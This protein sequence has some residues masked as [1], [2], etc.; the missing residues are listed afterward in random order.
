MTMLLLLVGSFFVFALLRIPLA[1]SLGLSS[2]LVILFLDVSLAT[3]MNNLYEGINQFTLLAVPLFLIAG[4]LMNEGKVTERLIQF[5]DSVVGHIRG[6]LGH[7]NVFVSMIF[8]G[9]S[10]SSA[11]DT[12]GIGSVLI[13]AMVK[14][15]YDKPFTVAITACSS[16]MG[17]IIPPS[18]PMIIYGSFG[19]VSIGSLFLGG[20]IPGILI[21]LTQMGVTY[22]Y[23]RKRNYP[24]GDPPSF[25]R[26]I[27]ATK[28][29][30]LPLGMPLLIVGG[31]LIGVF[32]ATE[33]SVMAVV[34]GLSLIFLIYKS[35]KLSQL[36]RILSESAVF[37]ALPMFAV[38]NAS[39]FGW[40]VAYLE[41]PERMVAL[42]QALTTSYYGIFFAII[43]ML[44]ILGTFLS[45]I[46]IIIIFLPILQAL[47]DLAG[48]H[49]VHLGVITV[50][51]LAIGLITPPY[52]ICLLIAV[53]IAELSVLKAFQAC[54]LLIAVFI[55]II[56]LCVIFPDLV[57][58]IPRTFMPRF[59]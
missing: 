43:A 26:I 32:T 21:G 46:V 2:V 31:I 5:S 14:A 16:T 52:G 17:I 49:P 41:G 54:F 13:P 30:V 42:I 56:V 55:G 4:W 7:V 22:Y 8:A 37:Y 50:M 27:Q 24:A 44:L 6:G 51:T 20:I 35:L 40:L 58:F 3:V 19:N 29:A 1:F 18:I 38:A 10:G 11:A 36:P 53:T 59:F 23:A 28:K 25:H 33:A 12:A 45:P 9:I 47:G 39:V 15:G 34:Y 48:I 57:L